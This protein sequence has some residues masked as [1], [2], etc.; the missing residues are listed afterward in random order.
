MAYA[1]TSSSMTNR[2]IRA[3][4]LEV[5]LYEEVEAEITATNQALL[6]VV[7]GAVASGI[8][9]LLGG[10]VGGSSAGGLVGLLIVGIL[11]ALIG[12]GVWSYVV[13]FVGTRYVG[14]WRQFVVCI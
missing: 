3:A 10:V 13:C 9:A 14:G 2:M 1:A 6:V 7:L 12:G 8:G 11:S 4:K 5:P